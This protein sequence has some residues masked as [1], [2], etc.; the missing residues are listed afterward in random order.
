M[1]FEPSYGNIARAIQ[2]VGILPTLNGGSDVENDFRGIDRC[3]R[4]CESHLSG[5]ECVFLDP[6]FPALPNGIQVYLSQPFPKHFVAR[7]AV[8]LLRELADRDDLEELGVGLD[9]V[10]LINQRS[11]V[12]LVP[13]SV[14][15]SPRPSE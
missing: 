5:L 13:S 6:R 1:S 2:K 9:T 4:R 10:A 3:F 11:F 14:C 15:K 7:L 8:A 12:R